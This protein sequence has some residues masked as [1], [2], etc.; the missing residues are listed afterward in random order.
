M[1][2]P[3]AAEIL[4]VA[5]GLDPRLRPPSPEDA[6]ARA[7]LW[8]QTLD[9]DMPPKAGKAMVGWHYRESTDSVMPAHLNR[10]WRQHRRSTADA[11]RQELE[12]RALT[13]AAA[14]SIPMPESVKKQLQ[15]ALT[16]VQIP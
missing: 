12:R 2:A 1:N 3:E 11:E 6:K 14:M 4:A 7:I 13:D 8:A 16:S 5:A 9:T 10:L 15:Q